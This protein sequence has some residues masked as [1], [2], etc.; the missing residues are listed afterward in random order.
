MRPLDEDERINALF[1]EG[2]LCMD[3]ALYHYGYI[4]KKPAVWHVA[5]KRSANRSQFVASGLPVQ[6]YYIQENLMDIGKSEQLLGDVPFA[7]YDRERVICDCFRFRSSLDWKVFEDI[8]ER[9]RNDPDKN[10][11]NLWE[12]A[13]L[14]R[15]ATRME[16]MLPDLLP[17]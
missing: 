6:E 7:M 10:L 3:T 12:Y 4:D 11:N 15:V 8:L 13:K 2:I 14:L 5:M 9:Y 16:K 17:D 1:P